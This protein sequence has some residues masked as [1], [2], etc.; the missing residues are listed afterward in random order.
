MKTLGK[1][2]F[3][4]LFQASTPWIDVRAPVE[5]AAGSIPGAVNLPILND[6]ERREVGILYKE[7]G[8][9]AAVARG[10]A[11]VSGEVK[12]KRVSAWLAAIRARPST[13]VYCFRGGMRSQIAQSWIAEAGVE[14]PIVEGGYKALRSFLS[15]CLDRELAR[16]RFQVVTGPTGSG[17]TEYLRRSGQFHIDLEALAGHRGS[18]FGAMARPQP[19]QIDFENH[20]ALALL[21]I[22]DSAGP[23]LIEDESRM[24]GKRFVPDGLFRVMQTS[25]RIRLEVSFERRVENIYREYVL[26]SALGTE[27][28]RAR[29]DEFRAAITAI[30]R[31]L[32]GLRTQAFMRDLDH[33]EAEFLAGRG[34]EA[35]REW[36]RRLLA[37]YYDPVYQKGSRSY[38]KR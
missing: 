8:Q 14:R 4:R 28:D 26:E 1:A 16:I 31:K 12:A 27:G 22:P 25:D 19:T 24:I 9:A 36:I 23:V 10:H 13:L 35:N 2:D 20:L 17:K 18:A 5:F 7:S 11:L 6:E 30:S 34:L 32:G 33:C 29:F 21:M 15:D 37:E 3:R 38:A